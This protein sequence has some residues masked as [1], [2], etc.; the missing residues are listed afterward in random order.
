MDKNVIFESEIS[1]FL[2]S[3]FDIFWQFGHLTFLK[4]DNVEIKCFGYFV[5]TIL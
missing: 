4:P 1:N 2:L 3:P 5:P